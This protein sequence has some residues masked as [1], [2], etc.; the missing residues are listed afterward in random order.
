AADGVMLPATTLGPGPV[1]PGASNPLESSHFVTSGMTNGHILITT[2]SNLIQDVIMTKRAEPSRLAWRH[3][4]LLHGG[5]FDD[6]TRE[7]G[8]VR[9]RPHHAGRAAVILGPGGG[10]CRR[11]AHRGR[12][13]GR[14]R[15]GSH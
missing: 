1:Q 11:R 9:A 2:G 14:R 12:R 8:H 4:W 10:G 6:V 13:G 5:A 7:M 15:R 3:R